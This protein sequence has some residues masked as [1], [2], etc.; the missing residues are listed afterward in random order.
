MNKLGQRVTQFEVRIE[1]LKRVIDESEVKGNDLTDAIKRLG[2]ELVEISDSL[3]KAHNAKTAQHEVIQKLEEAFQKVTEER[4]TA[5]QAFN[6][7]NIEFHKQQNR[8]DS[9]AQ[10]L[11]FKEERWNGTT[12]KLG[13]D[14][15]SLEETSNELGLKEQELS[16]TGSDLKDQY[17]KKQQLEGHVRS[18]E[19]LY[20]KAR[21]EVDKIDKQ[22]RERGKSKEQVDQLLQSIKDSF[23]KLQMQLLGMKE[24]LM[25][26]FKVELD[27]LLKQ[28]PSEEFE[29]DQLRESVVKTKG[30][31]EKYGQINPLAL[32]AFEEMKERFEFISKQRQDLVDARQTLLDTMA[33]IEETATTRFMDAFDQVRANFK[34]VF[35]SLFHKG[36]KCDLTLVD[37]SDPLD[38]AIDIL[39]KPKGKRPQSINQLSGGEKSL[40]ALALLFSLYLLKPAPFCIL[41]EVDAPLDDLN[42]GKFTN[43]IR[44]FSDRSQFIIVTHNKSTMASV[45]TIYGVTM[46]D[47]ISQVLPVSFSDLEA[48]MN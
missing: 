22:I 37:P 20:Y 46:Q 5:V 6:Q 27:D 40:T 42:V 39:A 12:K 38:S 10:N 33:E 18:A 9:I 31:I 8:V 43:I 44:D 36:D 1:N 25:I 41:D 11:K 34:E 26:E 21:A 3:Q 29:H 4:N 23:N 17:D 35:Q 24:R 32:E 28:D 2:E 7:E 15:K 16:L 19:D 30:R 45:D 14:E 47:N 13:F 48:Q